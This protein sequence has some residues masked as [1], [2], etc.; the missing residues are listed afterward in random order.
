[1]GCDKY[2]VSCFNAE[3]QDW[4]DMSISFSEVDDLGHCLCAFGIN[5]NCNDKETLRSLAYLGAAVALAHHG[6]LEYG[7]LPDCLPKN[8]KDSIDKM[9][10][11]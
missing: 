4:E 8:I 3:K 7:I 6:D 11:L 2:N 10:N 9:V 5:Y 1:M